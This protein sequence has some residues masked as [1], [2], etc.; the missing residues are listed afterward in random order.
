MKPGSP[1]RSVSCGTMPAGIVFALSCYLIWGVAPLYFRLLSGVPAAEI[2]AHRVI[3]SLLFMGAVLVGLRRTGWL[4]GLAHQPRVV[5]RFGLSALAV[6]ANWGVYIWAVNAGHVVDASLGYFINPL[7]NVAIG[8]L[9]LHERLRRVQ[10]IA[11]AIAAGGVLWLTWLAGTPPWIG[12]TLAISFSAYGLL[13]KTATLGAIEGLALETALLVPVA[14]AYLVVLQF[15]G[16][17]SFGTRPPVTAL[18][19]ATGPVT[20]VPLL[21]FAAAARRLPFSTLG[22]VQYLAPTMQLLI[23]VLLFGEPFTPGRAAGFAAI[24]LALLL[25]ALEGLGNA[26]RSSHASA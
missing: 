26:W 1:R 2:L 14:V 19:L 25:L 21:L 15:H 9:L 24:W 23:G 16:G 20:A 5:V 10:W 18:L 7:L 11:V 8:A 12:L 13:R 17:G 6:S 3:W 4:R 22:L